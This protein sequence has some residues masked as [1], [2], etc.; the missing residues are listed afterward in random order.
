MT[1]S[2]AFPDPPWLSELPWLRN[3]ARALVHEDAEVDDLVQDALVSTLEHPPAEHIPW[4]TTLAARLRN[5]ARSLYRA[6]T[7]RHGRER[8]IARVEAEEDTTIETNVRLALTQRIVTLISELPEPYRSVIR[9]RYLDDLMPRE[10]AERT[11]RN[12]ETVK[13]QLIRG[14]EMVRIELDRE[15]EGRR[16]EWVAALLPLCARSNVAPTSESE[17]PRHKRARMTRRSMMAATSLVFL[18]IVG[19]YVATRD[20]TPN[21]AGREFVSLAGPVSDPGA[22][23]VRESERASHVGA[24]QRELAAMTEP[25]SEPGSMVSASTFTGRVVDTHGN[26]VAGVHIVDLTSFDRG[27]GP[28]VMSN[29]LPTDVTRRLAKL[30]RAG[31][32]VESA[33]DGSFVVDASAMNS[34]VFAVGDAGWVTILACGEDA[35]EDRVIVVAPERTLRGTIRDAEGHPVVGAS[36]ELGIGSLLFAGMRDSSTTSVY[37]GS[38]LLEAVSDTTGRFNATALPQVPTTLTISRDGFATHREELPAE[39]DLALDIVLQ[40]TRDE[41]VLLRG[42]IVTAE[43]RPAVG[44]HASWI[45]DRESLADI[46]VDDHGRFEVSVPRARLESRG[47]LAGTKWMPDEQEPLALRVSMEGHRWKTMDLKSIGPAEEVV[48][49]GT[50]VLDWS[51]PHVSIRGR[52]VTQ[53]GESST[54]MIAWVRAAGGRRVEKV[55]DLARAECQVRMTTSF[56]DGAFAFDDLDDDVYCVGASL[57]FGP[58]VVESDP[59][60]GG[61]TDLVLRLPFATTSTYSGVVV[62]GLDRPFAGVRLKPTSRAMVAVE[63]RC[64]GRNVGVTD[65]AGRF[66]FEGGPGLD[67]VDVSGDVPLW[68][69]TCSIS[70]S[71]DPAH[72]QLVAVRRALLRVELLRDFADVDR[73]TLVDLVGQPLTMRWAFEVRGNSGTGW[74]ADGAPVRERGTVSGSVDSA[75]LRAGRSATLQVPETAGHIVLHRGGVELRRIPVR[76]E[77]GAVNVVKGG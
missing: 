49:L 58:D 5:R 53:A 15:H 16:D 55:S 2:S 67:S 62:D 46:D 19:G 14:L 77:A 44:A 7:R 8:T 40:P 25:S 35:R 75:P 10:I 57:P 59:I 9:Q 74:G 52:V 22:N 73:F 26:A 38:T 12:V 3:L 54:G 33:S 27:S 51:G 64:N 4:R 41:R 28:R 23:A 37:L 68:K 61:R 39:S 36:I 65:A 6:S 24:S 17:L 11:G 29:E 21:E 13:K 34:G 45:G 32:V 31:R 43:R 48:E 30:T 63:P 42:T 56:P 50:I 70:E 76:L 72:L 60:E 1:V 71:S 20:S 18:L 69:P 66:S 47:S